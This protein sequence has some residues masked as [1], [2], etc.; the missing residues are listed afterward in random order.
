MILPIASRSGSITDGFSYILVT[1]QRHSLQLGTQ[2]IAYWTS[3]PSDRPTI[4][5]IHGYRGTHHGLDRIARE[6]PDFH[7]II[8]DLPGFG[9]SEPF[10]GVHSVANYVAF[11]QDF[12]AALR[13][14]TPPIL[15]GHSFGSIVAGHFAASSPQTI[16]KLILVNPIGAPALQGP[17]GVLT[18]FARL[19]Y[20]IGKKLPVGASHAWLSLT[21]VTDIM[22]R[23]MTKSDDKDMKNYVKDQ[24]RRYFSRFAD[25]R[26]AS[27]AFDASVSNDVMQVAR[28]I[29]TSTLIIAGEQDDITSLDKIKQ[30]AKEFSDAQLVAIANVGHLIHYEK[31]AEAA[32]AIRRFI[33]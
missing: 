7:L 31:A 26:I 20:W 29:T 23:T 8:P 5:C 30:L 17:R 21:P 33:S 6:L 2:K 15:L 10:N 32:T 22:T 18:Q 14:S 28:R 24:H 4:V 19:Y 27:E 25:A 9:E 13:L 1:M 12:I 16:A 11:T 3:G